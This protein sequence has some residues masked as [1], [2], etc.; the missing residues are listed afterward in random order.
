[1]AYDPR[2]WYSYSK[3]YTE[4]EKNNQPITNSLNCPPLYQP[5]PITIDLTDGEK[6][7]STSRDEEY[8][9]CAPSIGSGPT[10]KPPVT[11]DAPSTNNK[12][13]VTPT[14][15]NKV[16]DP[17]MLDKYI[18]SLQK[19]IHVLPAQYKKRL[20][21]DLICQLAHATLDGTVFEIAKGLKDIQE[22]T[23]KNLHG[24]RTKMIQE[25]RHRK[26]EM[27][28]RHQ[29]EIASS[30]SRP[31]QIIVLQ[32]QHEEEKKVF[33]QKC[34]KETVS[35]DRRIVLELDQLVSDQQATLQRSGL[36]LFYITNK[37][38]EVRMQMYLLE[39]ITKLA[40]G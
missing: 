8:D 37:P 35:L 32:R 39:F 11:V 29:S 27:L 14:K 17:T 1:M 6:S 15:T 18:T 28:K 25:Q 30:Q 20:P 9:P 13:D 38:E 33:A 31:H 5:S 16:V 19:M 22:L 21:Y 40:A 36:P 4:P 34:E 24:K 12:V 3:S 23:E 2:Q 7:T 26:S 10:P